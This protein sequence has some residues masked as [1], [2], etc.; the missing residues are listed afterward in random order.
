[1][2]TL[3]RV[4]ARHPFLRDLPERY[5]PLVTGC[6]YQARFAPGEFI[7]RMGEPAN[8]FYLMRH[9]QVSLEMYAPGRGVLTLQTVGDDEALGWSWLVPPYTWFLDARVVQH[10]LTLAFDAT[11]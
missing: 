6:A 9:G 8:S 11:C 3:E 4:V 1:M 10:T 5:V 2:D 7:L